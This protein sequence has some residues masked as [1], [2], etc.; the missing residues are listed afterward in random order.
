M[1]L[2]FLHELIS[3]ELSKELALRGFVQTAIMLMWIDEKG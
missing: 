3:H 1:W 2:K